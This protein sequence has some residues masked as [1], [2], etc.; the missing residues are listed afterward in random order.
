MVRRI[1]TMAL[2]TKHAG[3]IVKVLYADK[4]PTPGEYRAAKGN[5]FHDISRCAGIWQ[6]STVLRILKD[7]RYIGT[8]VIG[9]RVLREV[10]GT[11]SRLKDESEWYKIPYHH[12]AIVGKEIY[13]QVQAKLRHFKCDK[14]PRSYLLRGK[15]ICGSCG[16]AMQRVPRKE[17]VFVC[18]YTKVDASAPCHRLEIKEQELESLLFD[19]ISKQVQILLNTGPLC[20]I[21]ELELQTEQQTEYKR[22]I[23]AGQRE[24]QRLYEQLILKEI[25]TEQYGIKKSELVAELSRLNSTYSILS[26]KAAQLRESRNQAGKTA[27]LAE[28][29]QKETGLTQETMDLLIDRI[30]VYPDKQ[31]E[32]TWKVTDFVNSYVLI[33]P[34]AIK[35]CGRTK[36]VQKE[37]RQPRRTDQ[38]WLELIQQ[39]RTS[40]MSDKDWC[41]LHHIQRSSFYYHIRRFRDSAC[42]IPEASLPVVHGKQEVVQLRISDLDSFPI[43][44]PALNNSLEFSSDTAIRLTVHGIRIEI[45]NAAAGETIKNTITAL[46]SLC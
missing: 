28:K 18:R 19:I 22:L 23:D 3:D 6:R 46:Q 34:H 1:F 12:P 11:R 35:N 2:E 29:L 30:Y 25:S 17:P 45:T 40:T 38:E 21:G 27:I 44:T 9:K 39:C 41:D 7:E 42:A 31:I 37:L 32:I 14:Q 13:D 16:H 20:A 33:D 15:V 26:A 4:I 43:Q 8:Y 10:G 24:K 36:M 5:G